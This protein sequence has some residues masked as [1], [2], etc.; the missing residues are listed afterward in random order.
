MRNISVSGYFIANTNTLFC[1]TSDVARK[2]HK[3][4]GVSTT[5]FVVQGVRVFYRVFSDI[6]SIFRILVS[7][8]PSVPFVHNTDTKPNVGV[9][10]HHKNRVGY[11]Y[12]G[13][14]SQGKISDS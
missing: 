2:I 3:Q 4:Q 12:L 5:F 11:G 1:Y 13:E 10:L 9:A 8:C 7:V 6:T 14:C